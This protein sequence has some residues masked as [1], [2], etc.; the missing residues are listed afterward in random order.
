M[1]VGMML[2]LQ[3]LRKAVSGMKIKLTFVLFPELPRDY[4]IFGKAEVSGIIVALP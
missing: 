4:P 1:Y 3:V 2:F